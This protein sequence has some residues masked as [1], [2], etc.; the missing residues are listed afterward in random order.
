MWRIVSD[1]I[2]KTFSAAGESVD[3]KMNMEKEGQEGVYPGG[4]SN[5]EYKTQIERWPVLLHFYLTCSFRC[6]HSRTARMRRRTSTLSEDQDD[7]QD[8]RMTARIRRRTSTLDFSE[9]QESSVSW[10]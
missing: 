8:D 3:K 10:D 2:R 9:D 1:S 6:V 7:S 5:S 4:R